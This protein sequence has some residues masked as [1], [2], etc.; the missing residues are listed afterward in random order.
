[1]SELELEIGRTLGASSFLIY[2]FI[3]F[4]PGVTHLEIQIETG[5]SQNCVSQCL[6]KLKETN[7]L[8]YKTRSAGYV[9][10]SQYS[11]NKEKETWKFH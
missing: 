11:E 5:L 3:K 7:V 2:Q 10:S 9:K 4:N 1:M 8:K 6:K